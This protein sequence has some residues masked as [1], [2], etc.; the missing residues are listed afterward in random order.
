MTVNSIVGSDAENEPSV[1]VP[2]S[3]RS[4]W[5]LL[6]GLDTL[7]MAKQHCRWDP[8]DIVTLLADT[9]E[10]DGLEQSNQQTNFYTQVFHY[11]CRPSHAGS[12]RS[13]HEHHPCQATK[14]R[15]SRNN[16]R[17]DLL[18]S[19]RAELLQVHPLDPPHPMR[20]LLHHVIVYPCQDPAITQSIQSLSPSP[21]VH[22][23][24][25]GR[26]THSSLGVNTARSYSSPKTLTPHPRVTAR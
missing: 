17:S 25:N 1:S 11:I 19:H 13:A 4:D 16:S 6:G 15:K 3:V 21:P 12:N 10:Q 14:Q 18:G 8:W 5:L 20:T 23:T 2:I 24:A 26:T 22:H 9:N 7:H